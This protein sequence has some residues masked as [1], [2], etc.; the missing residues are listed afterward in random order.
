MEDSLLNFKSSGEKIV[1]NFKSEVQALQTES[2]SIDFKQIKAPQKE[3]IAR[4]N[5]LLQ[6]TCFETSSAVSTIVANPSIF[7]HA[8]V[9]GLAT[10]SGSHFP[11]IV[12]SQIVSDEILTKIRA[13]KDI[14]VEKIRII[15]RDAT[16]DFIQIPEISPQDLEP[17]PPK[18][19]FLLRRLLLK[20]SNQR[21][22]ISNDSRA[23]VFKYGP[24]GSD[25]F[26][27]YNK[28]EEL[29]TKSHELLNEKRAQRREIIAELERRSETE[30]SKRNLGRWQ[31]VFG[32][33]LTPPHLPKTR[34]LAK[35]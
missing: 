19:F 29:F 2:G 5:T 15:V 27:D 35:K 1:N 16:T 18:E 34:L 11:M 23:P 3:A 10:F 7:A 4:L 9:L 6:R 31:M 26:A 8:E 21:H 17:M 25:K 12:E 32:E 30:K 22:L 13:Q 20:I 28:F 14:F 33:N 24:L